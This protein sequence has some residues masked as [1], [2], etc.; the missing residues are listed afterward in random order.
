MCYKLVHVKITS[1]I[2]DGQ[3]K[4]TN[5]LF[6]SYD[7]IKWNNIDDESHKYGSKDLKQVIKISK[8]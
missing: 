1:L 3:G 6:C 7:K 8:N 4:P 5:K 2:F